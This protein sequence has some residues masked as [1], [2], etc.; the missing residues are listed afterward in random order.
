MAIRIKKLVGTPTLKI[1]RSGYTPQF[2]VYGDSHCTPVNPGGNAYR[3][4]KYEA[5]VVVDAT[6]VSRFVVDN[7]ELAQWQAVLEKKG[8]GYR[9]PLSCELLT[10]EFAKFIYRKTVTELKN[11]EAINEVG[12]RLFGIYNGGEDQAFAEFIWKL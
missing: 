12:V 8:S 5:W 6:A 3:T 7:K 1:Y 9:T 10:V 4:L 2:E 11:K